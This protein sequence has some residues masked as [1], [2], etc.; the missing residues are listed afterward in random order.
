MATRA[1]G[2][3]SLLRLLQN[4]PD[5]HGFSKQRVCLQKETQQDLEETRLAFGK[6]FHADHPDGMTALP[7]LRIDGA[8]LPIFTLVKPIQDS[9]NLV[10]FICAIMAKLAST[11]CTPVAVDRQEFGIACQIAP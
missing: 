7:T 5:R 10:D 4:L 1:S 2:Y 8:K 9:T 6:Q 3:N 11:L